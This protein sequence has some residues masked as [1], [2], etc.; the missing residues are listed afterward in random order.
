ML[1]KVTT[2]LLILF[3]IAQFF[4][5]QKNEYTSILDTDLIATEKPPEQLAAILKESCYDCHSNNTTY[6]WYNRITPVNFW[7]NGHIK[8]AKDEL[9]FSEWK[10]YSAKKKVHK[11]DEII[12]VLENNEMP[13]NSYTLMHSNAKLTEDET[14]TLINWTTI[15]KIKYEITN[16]PQ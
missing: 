12:E 3:V 1:K 5:P 10:H 15:T 16:I 8:G 9:N 11:L 2:T 4:K 7:L 13:L 14:Q 6:P